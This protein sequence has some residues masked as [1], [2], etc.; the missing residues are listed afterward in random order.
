VSVP[1]KRE[2]QLRLSRSGCIAEVRT[3]WS[4]GVRGRAEIAGGAAAIAGAVQ[5]LRS[6]GNTALPSRARVLVADEQVYLSLLP[7]KLQWRQAQAA[8][9]DHFVQMLG[10]RDL[11]VQ[12][13][14]LPGGEVW[15]AG[16]IEPA[17]VQAWHEALAAEG[18]ALTE[19]QLA[20]IDDMRAIA[21][22]IDQHAI[23]ALLRDEGV[24][25]LHIEGGCP[26][27]LRWER[28]DPNAQH[29]VEQ[30]LL[31]FRAAQIS[32]HAAAHASADPSPVLLLCPSAAV[33]ESWHRIARAH[34]WTLLLRGAS[35][36]APISELPA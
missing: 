19:L 35:A 22:E 17:L 12:T 7:G 33:R 32:A 31:A 13:A 29:G 11:L 18:I 20:L 10:S 27:A 24:T 6:Q 4:R 28:C 30:R 36:E 14:P 9:V 3:P 26:K 5:A 15:L 16:A 34:R 21:P 8:A 1:W 25:L 2:L 23:V